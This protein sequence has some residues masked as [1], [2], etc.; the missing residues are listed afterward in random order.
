MSYL[1][2]GQNFDWDPNLKWPVNKIQ[3]LACNVYRHQ[4]GLQAHFD[5]RWLFDR[6][7][8]TLKMLAGGALGWDQHGGCCNNNTS[9]E[10][11]LPKGTALVLDS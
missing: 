10:L 9:F 6:P 1:S 3:M 11:M 4:I 7:I 2:T 5:F 8:I